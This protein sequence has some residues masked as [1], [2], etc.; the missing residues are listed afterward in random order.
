MVK[1]ALL[2]NRVNKI[3]N[4]GGNS[5]ISRRR[6]K[7]PNAI[8]IAK[9][10]KPDMA[11]QKAKSIALPVPVEKTWKFIS[12]HEI[13][14]T[15]FFVTYASIGIDS[16]PDYVSSTDVDKLLSVF[17]CTVPQFI[18]EVL[19]NV[20]FF[21]ARDQLMLRVF[22]RTLTRMPWRFF[23][24][25]ILDYYK[26]YSDVTVIQALENG[27]FKIIVFIN[28]D[29]GE[30]NLTPLSQQVLFDLA[31]LKLCKT[32][33]EPFTFKFYHASNSQSL[34]QLNPSLLP[35]GSCFLHVVSGNL[36]K[37]MS[38]VVSPEMDA[39]VDEAINE[40]LQVSYKKLEL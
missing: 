6:V 40:L 31:K 34:R 33:L 32:P 3:T 13:K 14:A 35:N 16:I 28:S 21:V 4:G 2:E 11:Q 29:F 8:A 15:P 26:A 38:S 36:E 19:V 18:K 30:I 24:F 12:A 23:L 20:D 22:L 7:L 39:D 10:L 1:P 27:R 25:R 9:V 37:M 5:P 17:Q